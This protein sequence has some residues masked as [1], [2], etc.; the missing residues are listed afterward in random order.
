MKITKLS[1]NFAPR[2]K[3]IFFGI[4]TEGTT[5]TNFVVEIIDAD[6]AEVVATQQLREVTSAEVNI[7][8]YLPRFEEYQPA[9]AL[10]TTISDTPYAR[11]KIRVGEVESEAVIVSVNRIE[12]GEVPTIIT[13]MPNRRRIYRGE[14]DEVLIITD[15]GKSISAE[16]TSDTGEQ[17]HIEHY[18]ATGAGTLTLS[19]EDFGADIKSLEITLYCEDEVFG[20]LHYSV[21]SAPKTATR[22]AWLSDAGSIERYTFPVSHK[23]ERSVERKTALSPEGVQT[24]LCRTKLCQSLSSQFEPSATIK[25]LAE[26]ASSTKVWVESQEGLK[27]VEVMS[28]S[29]E[30]NLFGESDCVCLDICTLNREDSLW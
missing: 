29:I 16:I 28:H 13:A 10:Y 3:G 26:I 23:V 27:S 25:A 20:R 18:V 14:C 8:P 22:L 5:P 12:A 30:Q 1:N 7:A 9:P 24:T 19:T 17:L 2:H 4:D 6:T 21:K 11:Y 15:G